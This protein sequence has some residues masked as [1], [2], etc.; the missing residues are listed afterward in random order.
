MNTAETQNPMTFSSAVPPAFLADATA[1]AVELLAPTLGTA[2]AQVAAQRLAVALAALAKKNPDI[3]ACTA[4]SVGECICACVV[5]DLVPGGPFPTCYVLPRRRGIPPDQPGGKWT[6][7]YELNWQIGFHGMLALARRAGYQIETYALYPGSVPQFDD[8]GRFILPTVRAPKVEGGRGVETMIGVLVKVRAVATGAIFSDAFVEA[9]LI[10]DRRAKSDAW[11]RGQETHVKGRAKSEDEARRSQS[12]PWYEWPEEMAL[13]TAIRYV[14]SRGMIPLDD[15]GMAAMEYDGKRDNVIDVASVTVSTTP[16]AQTIGPA[17]GMA[18]IGMQE[19]APVRDF[20]AEAAALDRREAIDVDA[21]PVVPPVAATRAEATRTAPVAVAAVND[22]T[23]QIPPA[24]EKATP[25]PEV[26][27]KK[28]SAYGVTADLAAAWLGTPMPA[29]T[30]GDV[31]RLIGLG[32]D[33]KA[34]KI[35]LS[36]VIDAA[37]VNATDETPAP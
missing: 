8:A 34:G 35:T 23:T 11:Q 21:A 22:A 6:N 26:V 9:D 25:S 7:V 15:A 33:L 27:A 3:L 14:V 16:E 36:A 18:A 20:A 17:R 13:K 5:A 30:T 10:E 19:R 28:L 24:T 29:W 4:I 31:R 32:V 12:S 37:K 2:K 1:A